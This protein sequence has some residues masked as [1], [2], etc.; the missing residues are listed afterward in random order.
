VRFGTA[1]LSRDP[2]RPSGWVLSVGDVAQSYVDVDDPTFLEFAYLRHIAVVLHCVAG[3]GTPLDAVHIGCA[4]CT[5]P[6]YL[7]AT[8]PGS[9]QVAVDADAE[10]MALVRAEFALDDVPGLTIVTGDGRACLDSHPAASA[11]LVVVD[12]FEKG[13]CPGGLVTLEA[14]RE[15]VRVLRPGGLHVVNVMDVPGLPFTRRVAATLMA[16]HRRVLMLIEPHRLDERS[17]ANV[18]LVGSAALPVLMIE[19]TTAV[20]VPEARC[21][22]GARLAAWCGGGQPLTD[23]APVNGPFTA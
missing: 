4:A 6:R 19:A 12:A 1:E 15:V 8:R 18:V 7:A 13:S 2:M 17:N 10:L 22:S 3:P 11:D 9:R 16:V 21:L 20:M 23:Q 5:L 14:T